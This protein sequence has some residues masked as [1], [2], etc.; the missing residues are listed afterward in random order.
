MLVLKIAYKILKATVALAW[1]LQKPMVTAPIVGATKPRQLDDAIAAVDVTLD[2]DD[3]EKL[4]APYLPL[5]VAGF[6]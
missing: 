2:D 6:Q 1:L 4:E 5:N 3:I